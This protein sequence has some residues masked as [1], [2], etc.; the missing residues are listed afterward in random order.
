M[1]VDGRE[2]PCPCVCVSLRVRDCV[3]V[4]A[5]ARAGVSVLSVSFLILSLYTDCRPASEAVC[6]PRVLRGRFQKKKRPVG[7][8]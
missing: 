7:R 1:C 6:R 5:R 3:C 4:R 2:E 8:T